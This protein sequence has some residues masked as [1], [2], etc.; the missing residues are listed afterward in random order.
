MPTIKGT[1]GNTT[2]ISSG[3]GI[4]PAWL[5]EARSR[6]KTISAG[7]LDYTSD[8]YGEWF[9]DFLD[10][11]N[12]GN[13]IVGTATAALD[14]GLCGGVISQQALAS[15]DVVSTS[16]IGT[17]HQINST[18]KKV[19][20]YWRVRFD[21]PVDVHCYLRVGFANIVNSTG[22]SGSGWAQFGVAGGEGSAGSTVNY[23][24]ETW[25]GSTN[26]IT[27]TQTAIDTASF[28]VVEFFSDGIVGSFY[29]DGVLQNVTADMSK[30]TE[31]PM[32]IRAITV[33]TSATA[34]T[35]SVDRM[36]AS[37][38]ALAAP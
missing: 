32:M 9:T 15:G 36:Y 10:T 1:D 30:V 4:E 25:N 17:A 28:H 3:S 26:P 12:W 7:A 6:A 37:F 5:S 22:G 16:P 24:V 35:M 18:T 2:G 20:G 19:Y 27:P 14:H 13:G 29:I 8:L 38:L 34:R 23:S 33:S 21:G 11:S 31:G